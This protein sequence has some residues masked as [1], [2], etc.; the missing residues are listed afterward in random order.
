MAA[1]L[2]DRGAEGPELV[3]FREV[4]ALDLWGDR[5]RDTGIVEE[6]MK[7]RNTKL[8][9]KLTAASVAVRTDT[10]AQARKAIKR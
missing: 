7:Q 4:L 1:F 10:P 5:N 8:Q 6:G 3:V 9:Q 2:N